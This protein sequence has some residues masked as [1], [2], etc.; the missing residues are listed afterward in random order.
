MKT[1]HTPGPWNLHQG[2]NDFAVEAGGTICQGDDTM[3]DW[4]AN[5]HLIAAAPELLEALNGLL[6]VLTVSG[7]HSYRP[8]S[9]TG[10]AIAGAQAAISKAESK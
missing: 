9:D 5:A 2:K 8:D 4:E 3:R 1:K 6:M 10:K 7:K